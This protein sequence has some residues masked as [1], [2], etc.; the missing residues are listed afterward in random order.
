MNNY[1]KF[2]ITAC[3]IEDS[4]SSIA[5]NYRNLNLIMA[6][7]NK[8]ISKIRSINLLWFGWKWSQKETTIL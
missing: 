7:T 1:E 5:L 6:E 2:S 8:F 3:V 4:T